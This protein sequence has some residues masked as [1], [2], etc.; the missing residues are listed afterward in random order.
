M[1]F[2]VL[3]PQYDQEKKSYIFKFKNPPKIEEVT[4]NPSK[5]SITEE[6][7]TEVF[8]RDFL[9]QASKYFSKPLDTELFYKRVAYNWVTEDLDITRLEDGESFR[10]TWIPA[11]IVFYTSRYELTFNLA[12]L[13][14]VVVQSIPPGFLDGLG[15][16]GE[17]V[18]I[19][20]VETE[21]PELP[22]TEISIPFG[23][24][25]TEEREKREAAR[26]RV[27]QARLRASLA[28]LRAEKLADRYFSRYGNFDM[29]GSGSEL[30]SEEES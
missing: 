12:E 17:E 29:D 30:S 9:T 2:Q 18:Q 11:T 26:K 10:A 24:L 15:V 25:S 3:A 16:P 8:I 20:P 5:L 19:I 28:R 6:D 13:E 22:I 1:S 7:L 14:P 27:R 21:L 23:E 4:T